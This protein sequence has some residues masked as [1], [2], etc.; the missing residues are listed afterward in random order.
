MTAPTPLRDITAKD[1]QS[2]SAY[3]AS[4][5]PYIWVTAAAISVAFIITVSLLLL[6]AARGLPNFWPSVV[7]QASYT[8]PGHEPVPMLAEVV[9][10]EDVT[11]ARLRNAGVKLQDERPIHTRLLVKRGNR[12]LYGSDFTYVLDDWLTDREMPTDAVVIER[13]EWGNFYGR[14]TAVKQGGQVV[15]SGDQ[16]WE[17]YLPLQQRANE[18]RGK[19]KEIEKGRIGA[20]NYELERL[21]LDGR[22]LELARRTPHSDPAAHAELQARRAVP[23]AARRA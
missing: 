2:V 11:S 5:M 15:A 21:R 16:A 19:I 20:I 18:L 4:G 14:I 9:S 8:E 17:A 10:R 13:L 12:D 3:I 1:R 7:L 22:R 23:G 6:T